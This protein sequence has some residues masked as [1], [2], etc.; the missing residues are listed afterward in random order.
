MTRHSPSC[1]LFSSHW[2]LR[3]GLVPKL[4]HSHL[5]ALHRSRKFSSQPCNGWLSH[6]SGLW[7]NVTSLKVS[8]LPLIKTPLPSFW[9]LHGYS[10]VLYLALLASQILQLPEIIY[11][12]AYSLSLWNISCT[13]VG[14]FSILL[15]TMSPFPV[16]M[17]GRYWVKT[18]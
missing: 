17:P 12:Y 9:Y 1:T 4:D 18:S 16:T 5:G 2:S 10:W 6:Q 15:N 8:S 7:W 11:L 13:K 14:H 3:V